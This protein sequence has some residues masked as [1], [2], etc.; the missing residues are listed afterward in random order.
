MFSIFKET[1]HWVICIIVNPPF[2]SCMQTSQIFQFTVALLLPFSLQQFC[3]CLSIYS[4][5]V[6]VLQFTVAVF[7]LSVYSSSVVA[8]KFTVLLLLSFSLQQFSCCLSVGCLLQWKITSTYQLSTITLKRKQNLGI[9]T[10][11]L[12]I[13]LIGKESN[14]FTNKF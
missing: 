6:V 13:L 10:V 9:Y 3:C 12:V 5:S 1:C 4:S 14:V 11:L 7:C 2:H 8:F